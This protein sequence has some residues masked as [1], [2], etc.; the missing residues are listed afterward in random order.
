MKTY[1]YGFPRL[2]EKREFKRATEAYWKG[3]A[4]EAELW[5]ALDAL[6][7]ENT[8]RYKKYVEL[9]PDG[10]MSLY[11]PMLDTAILF[12]VFDPKNLEEYYS[13]CRGEGALE[14]TKWFNTNYHYLVAD[15]GVL[16]DVRFRLNAEHFA[17]RYKRGAFPSVIGP[18]TFLKL[19]KGIAPATFKKMFLALAAVYSEFISNFKQVHIEEP[20]FVLDL[21]SKEIALIKKGYRRLAKAGSQ[22]SLFVYYDEVDWLDDLLDLPVSRIGLDFVRGKENFRHI[23]RKGF[24]NDKTLVAGLVGGR[25]VWRNDIDASAAKLEELKKAVK[26][27]AVSNAAPLYHLPVTLRLEE[28]MLPSLKDRLAFA[29]EKLEEIA[30]IAERRAGRVVTDEGPEKKHLADCLSDLAVQKRVQALAPSDFIKPLSREERKRIHGAILNLPLFPT[31]TIGSFPQTKEVR[32]KRALNI[33]GNI[34]GQEYRDYIRSKIDEVIG[35]Q[36]ALRLDVL[37]HGEFERTDMVEFFAQRLNGFVTT[38]SGWII[39]YGTRTYRPPIICGDVSRP[40]PMTVDEIVYAQS[41]TAKPVK[42]ML[43]GPVTIIAWSFCREDIPESETAFQ[44]ALSLRDEIMDYE[45]SGIK[46]VQVD[47]PAFRENAPNKKRDWSGYFDWAAK[48]F[49]LTTNTDPKTQIHTHMCYS[50]F[51]EIIRYINQMD[52]DVIT[53]EAARSKGDIISSFEADAFNRQI[54]VG[55]WDIHSPAVPSV[56]KMLDVVQRALQKIS[57]ET[58]WLNPDC[59]LK[60]REWPEVIQALGHMIDTAEMLRR[61]YVGCCRDAPE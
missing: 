12:G 28:R 61:A 31:T 43:T 21:T 39:S 1:A 56:E 53:I 38:D 4:G 44:I 8:R 32:S 33:K 5:E 49:N 10:E 58:F 18:F 29:E 27:L 25:N 20:A 3:S 26:D 40:H 37:V 24:P 35:I 41:K 55:V 16:E 19:S 34:S 17:V 52:F 57:K 45:K 50:E 60:T 30:L 9:A 11:D 48:S 23:S 7:E 2:G 22:L 36:D 47:E 51:G 46:I 54:G 13:L 42:G 6:Q 14:M 15:F 59:G